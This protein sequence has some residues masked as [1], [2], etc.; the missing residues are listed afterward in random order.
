MFIIIQPR[1]S[2]E[3]N[4]DATDGCVVEEAVPRLLEAWV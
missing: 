1:N 3:V 4:I 2:V